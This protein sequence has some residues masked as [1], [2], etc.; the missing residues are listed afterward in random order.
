MKTGGASLFPVLLVGFLAGLTFWLER[1]SHLDDPDRHAKERHD[2]DFF[3]DQFRVR[4]YDDDGALLNTLIA[5]KMLHFPDDESTKVTAPYLVYHRTPP[6]VV[7]AK[8][9]WLDKD[10]KHVRLD[11]D[12]RLVRSG[13]TEV[14]DTV[15]STSVL[16]AVPDDEYAHTDAPVVITQGQ[17]VINGIGATVDNK[18]QV[19]VLSGPVRGVIHRNQHR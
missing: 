16:Y 13:G 5:E 17:T 19:S 15:I 2:P 18:A 7:T 10:G 9:A 4:R 8:T 14:P 12:V 3:V 1:A 11:D 6:T